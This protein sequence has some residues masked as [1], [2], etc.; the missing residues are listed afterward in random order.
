MVP[1]FEAGTNSIKLPGFLHLR[2]LPSIVEHPA[3]PEPTSNP[4]T[5]PTIHTQYARI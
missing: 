2:Y 1:P 4:E 3:D 5:Q